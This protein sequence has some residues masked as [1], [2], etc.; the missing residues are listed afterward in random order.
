MYE[1]QLYTHI[2]Q[3]SSG[4][5]QGKFTTSIS[6]HSALKPMSPVMM[7]WIVTATVVT[8]RLRIGQVARKQL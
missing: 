7:E 2:L 4:I 1:L 6:D 8:L 5:H 3:E